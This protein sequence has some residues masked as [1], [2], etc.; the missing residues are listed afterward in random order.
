MVLSAELITKKGN[1]A[2]VN[3]D[4]NADVDVSSINPLSERIQIPIH[5]DKG[6]G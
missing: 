4:S 1:V 2:T 6:V 3:R 5:S